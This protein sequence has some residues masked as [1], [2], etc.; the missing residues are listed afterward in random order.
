M[1]QNGPKPLFVA[2]CGR[3]GTTGLT[4]YLNQ[5][6]SILVCIERYKAIPRRI[7]PNHFAFERILDYRRGETNIP[8]E[9]QAQLLEGKDPKKLKWAGDKNPGY[10]RNFE[11][12]L[13]NNPGARFIVIYRPVEEVAESFDARAK[14]PGDRWLTGKDGI[15]TG[16]ERWNSSLRRT[17]EFIEGGMGPSV[18]IVGYH[19]FFYRNEA[20][21]PLVS[22]F[23]DLEFDESVREA[24][25]RMSLQ[26][27]K[28]RR[29]KEPLSAEQKAFIQENKDHAAE[30]WML[31]RIERQW[32]EPELYMGDPDSA[33]DE[34][35]GAISGVDLSRRLRACEKRVEQLKSG[36][37]K[38][39]G[40]VRRLKEQRRQTARRMRILER[41]IQAM[42]ESAIWKLSTRLG[43]IKSRVMA[44]R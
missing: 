30:E 24:W 16:V 43:R 7:T 27:E 35:R 2:G 32:S 23:L 13:E 28:R 8:R 11:T 22:R 1:S 21:V 20:C 36:L 18:L 10:V 9:R 19:D 4:Y 25:K 14:D 33:D 38:E 42:R 6:E 5:H 3:S 37:A 15:E 40:K 26:F 41:S 34:P 12:L 17:R 29:E 44:K 31:E 39:R